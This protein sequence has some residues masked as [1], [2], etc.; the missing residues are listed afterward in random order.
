MSH[1]IT[2]ADVAGI[3]DALG[4]SAAAETIRWGEPAPAEVADG[5]GETAAQLTHAEEMLENLESLLCKACKK[6]WEGQ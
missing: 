3:L 1:P 4:K 5:L 6:K 2:T